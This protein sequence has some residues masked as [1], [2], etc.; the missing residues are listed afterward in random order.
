MVGKLV[1]AV[2]ALRAALLLAENGHITESGSL[3]R[4][5]SDFCTEI[6]AIGEALHSGDSLPKAVE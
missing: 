6:Q 4:M 2:S 5:V 1:R 3:L